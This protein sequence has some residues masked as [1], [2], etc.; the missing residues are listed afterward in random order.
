MRSSHWLGWTFVIVLVLLAVSAVVGRLAYQGPAYSADNYVIEAP[1]DTLIIGAS[2]AATGLNPDFLEGA[3]SVARSGEPLF[4]TYYKTRQLLASNPQIR[5]VLVSLSSI[6]VCGFAE[7]SFFSGN[8]ASRVQSMN[9]YPLMD[10]EAD[11]LLPRFSADR[12][13]SFLKYKVGVPFNYMDDTR[14]VLK[15]YTGGLQPSEFRFYG[16]FESFEET[17]LDPAQVSEKAA[18]Y[19]LGD[20]GAAALSDV[21]M[22][23]IRR[24][25]GLSDTNDVEV[26][27][28][29]T[30]E[31]PRFRQATPAVCQDGYV[32]LIT[33]RAE[34]NNG[35]RFFDY[36]EYA[37]PDDHFLDGDHL[38]RRG[39]EVF[40]ALLQTRLDLE[41]ANPR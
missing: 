14:V 25:L 5:R 24:L 37:L 19:F 13:L 7:Y 20:A 34:A 1:G 21:G 3:I 27:V 16:G 23:S 4:F 8:S 26:V 11:P 18:F 33:D 2:H 39:S 22:E 6:H 15:H 29:R 31:H 12:W 28:V 38:N 41:S 35:V 17:H 30:P 10:D 32:R 40:S 9:Y 36:G